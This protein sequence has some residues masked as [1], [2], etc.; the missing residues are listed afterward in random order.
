MTV[1]ERL[2]ACRLMDK[3]DTAVKNRNAATII[4]ILEEVELTE[5]TIIPILEKLRLHG[6]L[7][8][9]K[10]KNFINNTQKYFKF[11]E[12]EFGFNKPNYRFFEQENRTVISD[13]IEYENISSNKKIII[14]NN[15]HPV[16]YGF[17]INIINMKDGTSEMLSYVLKEKQ[18]IK[19]EYLKKQAE[20]LRNYYKNANLSETGHG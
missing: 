5:K 17:E 2:Y 14:S 16:D 19:Q 3:F 11:L 1:D 18:D 15:Y 12:T 6:E 20:V 10:R 13:Y 7:Y 9:Y 8:E 4:S